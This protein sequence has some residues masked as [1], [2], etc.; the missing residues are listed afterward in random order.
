[1]M[2]SV[3][4]SAGSLTQ[5]ALLDV[6][7]GQNHHRSAAALHQ[8]LPCDSGDEMVFVSHWN[9]DNRHLPRQPSI[10]R[11]SFPLF[12][13]HIAERAYLSVHV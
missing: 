6:T 1:M 9:R 10:S 2:T 11:P 4:I 13:P 3:K 7:A 12:Q 5:I 8:V